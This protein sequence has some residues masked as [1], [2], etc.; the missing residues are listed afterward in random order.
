MIEYLY[1]LATALIG[2][3]IGFIQSKYFVTY[4]Y[5]GS[6]VLLG[7][8]NLIIF[9]HNLTIYTTILSILVILHGLRLGSFI[10]I[11][12]KNSST[13]RRQIDEDDEKRKANFMMSLTLWVSCAL[14]Y[15]FEV[16]PI[17]YRLKNE[18]K[19]DICALIGIIITAMG[20]IMESLADSQKYNFKKRSPN[21]FCDTGLF[22]VVRFPN[23]LGEILI[24]FG[25]FI[26][27]MTI[28]QGILQWAGATFGF[29]AIGSTMYFAAVSLEKRQNQNYG[30][31]KE[32]QEY[33]HKT[34]ILI[35]FLP[36]YSFSK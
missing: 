4:G 25:L 13:Y 28:Y 26:S 24:W 31:N 33:I 21:R 27:G 23:Y 32:Y 6:I 20:L 5:T 29:L 18:N 12:N 7:L 17:S 11:R 19:D 14:I 35:P 9:R 22:T 15:S 16:I 30:D 2:T 3:S 1:L 8:A 36:I 10:F 34:P